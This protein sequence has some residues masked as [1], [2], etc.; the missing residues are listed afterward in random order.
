M[1]PIEVFDTLNQIVLKDISKA[2]VNLSK[3]TIWFYGTESNLG[4]G[5]YE[6]K[7]VL[8]QGSAMDNNAIIDEIPLSLYERFIIS[9]RFNA[10][11]KIVTANKNTKKST[12]EDIRN[13]NIKSA[14]GYITKV[15]NEEQATN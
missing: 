15:Q 2:N 1:T 3:N 13:K 11:V 6:G 9:R 5:P 12:R 4:F 10:L 14:V 8:R 7:L